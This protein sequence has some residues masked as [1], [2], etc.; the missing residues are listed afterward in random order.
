MDRATQFC[1]AAQQH[2]AQR[3]KLGW[4]YPEKLR[5]LAL[6]YCRERREA[7]RP[8]CEIA[9]DLSITTTTLGRWLDQPE[10]SKP[11]AARFHPVR[12]V[13]PPASSSSRGASARSVLTPGGLRIEGLELSE[14]LELARVFR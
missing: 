12:V 8:F 11:P 14:V 4:R 5:R 3:E 2:N 7:D 1:R 9:A 10:P 6:E 13:E